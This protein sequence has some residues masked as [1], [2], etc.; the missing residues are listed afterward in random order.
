MFLH[1]SSII[2]EYIRVLK[3]LNPSFHSTYVSLPAS[4]SQTL[5]TNTSIKIS[6][7]LCRFTSDHLQVHAL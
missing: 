7:L 1:Q 4:P 2:A 3:Y 5:M 6:F